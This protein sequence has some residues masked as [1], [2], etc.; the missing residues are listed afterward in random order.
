MDGAYYLIPEKA[1]LHRKIAGITMAMT[2]PCGGGRPCRAGLG[3]DAKDAKGGRM[4]GQ[5]GRTLSW[6]GFY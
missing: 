3:Q 6:R 4:G 2:L 5:S 1:R